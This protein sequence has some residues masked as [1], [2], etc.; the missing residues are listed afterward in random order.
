M[1]WQPERYV[2]TRIP[3][4]HTWQQLNSTAPLSAHAPPP[5]SPEPRAQAS[6]PFALRVWFLRITC[7]APGDAGSYSVLSHGGLACEVRGRHC[8]HCVLQ[9]A[10]QDLV[11]LGASVH[12]VPSPQVGL[13]PG[14][15][16]ARFSSQM[17]LKLSGVCSLESRIPRHLLFTH[18]FPFHLFLFNV[19]VFHCVLRGAA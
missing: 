1:S 6:L 4:S 2:P 11:H 12:V 15:R 14:G 18:T 3:P 13:S 9:S 16:F 7:W 17:A 10:S 19:S 8:S 5:P